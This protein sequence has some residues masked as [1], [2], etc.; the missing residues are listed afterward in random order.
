MRYCT[1][2]LVKI[3]Q[4]K[5]QDRYWRIVVDAILPDGRN[6]NYEIVKAG[7]AWWFREHTP[8]DM[9]LETLELEARAA[10]RGLWADPNP[11]PTWEY[12]AIAREC[13]IR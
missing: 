13:Q 11:V 6:L 9:Q 10:K 4:A 2:N 8:G 3:E 12:R 7:F 1:R 5:R